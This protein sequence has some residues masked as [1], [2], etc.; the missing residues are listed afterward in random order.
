MKNILLAFL[1]FS[2]VV[3]VSIGQTC[4]VN[5]N[6]YESHKWATHSNW[7]FG[8]G[9][10]LNFGT[11]GNASPSVKIQYG[12]GSPF[13][14]Y[15]SCASVSDE[16]G[17]LILF[18]NGVKLW[19]E[20]GTEIAIPGGRLLTGSEMQLGGEGS[21]TQGVIIIKHPLELNQYYIFTTDDAISGTNGITNGFNYFVY[22]KQSN[23]C[24]GATRLGAY[25]TTEQVAATWH[26]N[27]MDIWVSTHES[28]A[29]GSSNFQSYLLTCSG[30]ETTPITS[31]LGFSVMQSSGNENERGALHFSEDGQKAAQTHHN[32]TGTWDPSG[33]VQI[34]DFN[35]T[36]GVFS[37]VESI[38]PNNVNSSTPLDCE[39]SPNGNRLYVSNQC[40]T[41]S[42]IGYYDLAS[43]NNY[44]VVGNNASGHQGALKLGGDG[45]L[46]VGNFNQCSGWGYQDGIGRI[47]NPDGAATYTENAITV[48]A[49][50][51]AFGLPNMF[52]PPQ[53]WLEIQNPGTLSECDIPYN[54]NTNWSCKGTDAENT[55][56]YENAYAILGGPAGANID[57]ITGVFNTSTVGTYQITFTICA[58]AD[59]LEFTIERCG[60]W[61]EVSDNANTICVGESVMLDSLLQSASR[62][63]VWTIDSIPTGSGSTA[64]IEEQSFDTLFT[65]TDL[66]RTGTYKVMYS[67]PADGCKDSVYITVNPCTVG[68]SNLDKKQS[69]LTYPNPINK[70]VYLNETVSEI[71]LYSIDGRRVTKSINTNQLNVN[72]IKQGQYFLKISFKG[73]NYHESI[74]IQD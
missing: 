12:A 23:T 66:T 59:T 38:A 19:D 67:I 52:V 15:E 62:D 68:Y 5:Y 13:W 74:F 56:L 64:T 9:N 55:P 43:S 72:S 53:D 63:G 54:L 39:F 34:M 47:Q 61:A 3:T 28:S 25:R 17:N 1:I 32:G 46:Y 24:S 11:S 2:T 69:L 27:G 57:P 36:T 42:E 22:D 31:S 30:L 51:A 41:G 20:Y 70:V 33:S 18:T 40:I 6:K 21:A 49:G 50:T 29:S 37:N 73:L 60:C 44:T 8:K 4:S 48:T 10:M 65:T 58:V 71:E 26:A 14:T 16:S 45:N 35:N 7:F